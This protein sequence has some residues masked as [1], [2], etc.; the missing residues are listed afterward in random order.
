[1]SGAAV[2][3]C[4]LGYAVLTL[5][6]EERWAWSLFQMAVFALAAWRVLRRTRISLD[7]AA[8]PLAAAAMW[9]LLQ[10]AWGSSVSQARTLDAALNWTT[11]LVVFALACDLA[12]EPA[13]RRRLLE[14]AAAFGMLSAFAAVVQKYSS[15]GRIFWL[16]PSGYYDNVLGPF[17][18]HGQFAAWIE[19]LLPIALYLAATSRMRAFFACAAAVLFGAAIAS[20]SR[21]GFVLAAG[22]VVVVAAAL[23]ARRAAPR[24]ALALAVVQFAMLASMAAAIAGWQGLAARFEVREPEV[25]RLDAARASLAMVRERPWTGSGIG[26]WPTVY[27]RFAGFDTGAYVNQAHNDWLQWA[28]EGG[29]PFVGLLAIFAAL[30][31]KPAVQSMYG[32]GTVAFL[33]HALVDY[34]MQQRPALAAWF[35]AVAGMAAASRNRRVPAYDGPLRRTRARPVGVSGGDPAG[36]QTPGAPAPSRPLQR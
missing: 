36:L 11:F 30:L 9:P 4:L 8:A 15:A 32:L 12:L 35:F 13:V 24:K 23:A 10:L 20:A 18:N 14:I 6:V 31:C 28:A 33:L 21:A 29:L 16:F 26:T 27:P 3:A 17:V 22:E 7:W 19:L 34:P 1:M 25:L 2:L 5:W